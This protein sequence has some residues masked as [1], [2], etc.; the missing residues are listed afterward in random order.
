MNDEL[1]NELREQT[2]WLRFLA[3]PN[4]LGVIEDNLKTKE[5][6][7]IY[8]LSEGKNSSYEIARRLKGEG[9]PI[10]HQ[11]VHNYWKKWFAL[12]IVV[13][14]KKYIGRFKQII[15][16]KDLNIED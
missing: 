14:S 6:R 15:D 5:Q 1:L 4:L 2:K 3:L 10:S 9:I 12:G 8:H 16:L 13:H 11:T 7:A